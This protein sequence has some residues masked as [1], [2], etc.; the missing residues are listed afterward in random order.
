MTDELLQPT[1]SP[2]PQNAPKDTDTS[3]IRGIDAKRFEFLNT[4]VI[5]LVVVL[6]VGFAGMFV[7]C[8][9]MLV[10]AWRSK[11]A[12]YQKLEDSIETQNAKIDAIIEMYKMQQEKIFPTV[13]TSS[14]SR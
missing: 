1:P 3:A 2:A 5:A 6:F 8:T 11:D 7:A 9:A 12:T 10:D 4:I 14:N 13:A